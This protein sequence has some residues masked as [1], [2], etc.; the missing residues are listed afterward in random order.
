[1]TAAKPGERSWARTQKRLPG[2]TATLVLKWG[3]GD[4]P[5]KHGIQ[6]LSRMFCEEMATSVSWLEWGKACEQTGCLMPGR[7]CSLFTGDFAS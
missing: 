2:P 4:E 5:A 6:D 7:K 3:K 1:M